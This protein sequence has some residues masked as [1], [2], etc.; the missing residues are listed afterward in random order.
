MPSTIILRRQAR[1]LLP[2]RHHQGAA[3]TTLTFVEHLL[4]RLCS[5]VDVPQ[6]VVS[7]G[8]ALTYN[9]SNFTAS[10]GTSVT[11]VFPYD[12]PSVVYLQWW[13]LHIPPTGASLI[14]SHNLRSQTPARIWQRATARLLVSIPGY[15][16][17]SNLLSQSQMIKNVSQ[18]FRHRRFFSLT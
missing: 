17:G 10:N 15:R 2:R 14:P 7:P 12:F 8:G 1:P 13:Y 5:F 9:P 16:P 18:R 3:R 11:F 4:Y 6:V